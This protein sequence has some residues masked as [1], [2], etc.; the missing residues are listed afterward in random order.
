MTPQE[1]ITEIQKLPPIKRKEVLE[2]ISQNLLENNVISEAEA[3]KRLLKK[4]IIIEIPEGWDESDED[5]EPIEIKGK[6]LSETIIEDR[7]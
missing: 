5:F 6:P 3:A 4:G 1:I 7:R 2:G